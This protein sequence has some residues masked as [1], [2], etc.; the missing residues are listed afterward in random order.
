MNPVVRP[1]APFLPGFAVIEHVGRRSGQPYATPVNAFRV[2][3]RLYVAMGHGRTDWI[4]NTLAAGE[5][6][7]R[8]AFRHYRLVNPRVVGRG[9]AG[10][11]FP[12]AARIAARR[13]PLFVAD[14][15]AD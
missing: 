14:V 5:A 3:G 6:G 4:R 2:G 15:A 1:V 10:S 7:A 11:E 12:L 8:Y 9:E 13:L